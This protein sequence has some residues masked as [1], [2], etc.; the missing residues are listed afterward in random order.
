MQSLV[1]ISKQVLAIG[2]L[3]WLLSTTLI[4]LETVGFPQRPSLRKKSA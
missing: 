4:G 3:Q 1:N 2:H